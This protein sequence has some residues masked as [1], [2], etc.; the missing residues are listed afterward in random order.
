MAVAQ[1]T[2]DRL[3][4]NHD[5]IT[6]HNFAERLSIATRD[7]NQSRALVKAAVCSKSFCA[8]SGRR[9][10]LF[11][12]RPSIHSRRSEAWRVTA[13]E[14]A[15]SAAR[16]SKIDVMDWYLE[17]MWVPARLVEDWCS[18]KRYAKRPYLWPDPADQLQCGAPMVKKL[19]KRGPKEKYDWVDI[20]FRVFAHMNTRGDFDP[21]RGW[22]QAKLIELLL[23]DLGFAYRD[24]VPDDSTLKRRIPAFV[25]A[26]RGAQN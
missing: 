17:S 19:G 1:R 22:I 11:L 18:K 20:E 26:W 9:L 25:E 23:E 5:W 2:W 15:A 13:A 8:A 10:V 21:S 3:A 24:S 6:L 14:Y 4:G 7:Q 12:P 16:F